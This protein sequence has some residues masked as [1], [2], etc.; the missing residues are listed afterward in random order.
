[1][2]STMPVDIPQNPVV[3]QQRQEISELQFDNFPYP[4]SF[5]ML[6]EKIQ[7]SSDYLF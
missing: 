3:G 7:Q 1:M 5:F 4:H 2:S 6:E